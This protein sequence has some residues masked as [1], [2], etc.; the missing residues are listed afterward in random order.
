MDI[1]RMSSSKFTT[2]WEAAAPQDAAMGPLSRFADVWSQRNH[3]ATQA[4][5]QAQLQ[6]QLQQQHNQLQQ[7][8]AQYQQ[9]QQYQ[10]PLTPS[11]HYPDQQQNGG[12]TPP[13]NRREMK[14]QAQ[15][16][17]HGQSLGEV[18][19]NTVR[20][21]PPFPKGSKEGGSGAGG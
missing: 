7:Q 8:H 9:E 18:L 4:Q 5:M 12:E 17:W 19:A 14:L 1:M 11:H 13:M 16:E 6:Q 21:A 3:L 2:G 10:Q 20:K 15:Q